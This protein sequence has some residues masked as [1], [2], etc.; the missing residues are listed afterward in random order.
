M[1]QQSGISDAEDG[2]NPHV[3]YIIGDI[4]TYIRRNTPFPGNRN[5]PIKASLLYRVDFLR[6][7]RLRWGLR[8]AF[9]FAATHTR[10]AGP[11]T[12]CM[13]ALHVSVRRCSIRLFLLILTGNSGPSGR[14][15][16]Q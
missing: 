14:L 9:T 4:T 15:F 10:K 2:T 7:F 16:L 3:L 1:W 8:F 11:S 5:P 6:V 13:N 12:S